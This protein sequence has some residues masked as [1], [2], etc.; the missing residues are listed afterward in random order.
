MLAACLWVLVCGCNGD[1]PYTTTHVH[2]EGAFTDEQ[3]AAI[4]A[5][6]HEWET[7]SLGTVRFV[8]EDVADESEVRQW[9]IVMSDYGNEEA[10]KLD[11]AEAVSRGFGKS[12]GTTY[13][14][15]P[16]LVSAAH[17]QRV[18]AHEAGH[19]LGIEHHLTGVAAMSVD[20]PVRLD[21][22]LA[23]NC[24]DVAA[25]CAQDSMVGIPCGCVTGE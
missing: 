24:K 16:S 21:D 8:F 15:P 11:G 2:F 17:L 25:F 6:L 13:F 5:G 23:V 22:A 20:L 4:A 14:A 12:Y 19:V 10:R 1:R 9:A 7:A 3:T 18:A